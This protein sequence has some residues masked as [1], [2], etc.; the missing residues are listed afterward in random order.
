VA[1]APEAASLLVALSGAVLLVD[2]QAR[3]LAA[4]PAAQRLL[5]LQPGP[6]EGA[7]R[8]PDGMRRSSELLSCLRERRPA[9]LRL[10]TRPRSSPWRL[11]LTPLEVPAG[12]T[13]LEIFDL[14][15]E[16]ALRGQVLSMHHAHDDLQAAHEELLCAY[17]IIEAN[18]RRDHITQGIQEHENQRLLQSNL[19]LRRALDRARLA[20]RRPRK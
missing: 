15:D 12:M 14:S 17:E 10:T 7:G 4:S 18:Q 6:E 11:K 16:A 1:L 3:L 20:L 9:E 2:G 8:L 13:L 19:E 5:E